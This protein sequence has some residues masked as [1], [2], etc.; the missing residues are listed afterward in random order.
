MTLPLAQ[1]TDGK[2]SNYVP[3]RYTNLPFGISRIGGKETT[4]SVGMYV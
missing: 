1:R 2:G 3:F 4:I